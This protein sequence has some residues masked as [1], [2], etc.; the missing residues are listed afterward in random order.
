M[1]YLM[2][3]LTSGF[4]VSTASAQSKEEL[5][6]KEACDYTK[7]RLVSKL[8]LWVDNDMK[9]ERRY[10]Y[11]KEL[12]ESFEVI[13][14]DGDIDLK[15]A[16]PEKYLKKRKAIREGLIDNLN[17]LANIYNAVCKD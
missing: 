4:L 17:A 10:E 14:V 9:L 2:I 7:E 15:I 3:L 13:D 16:N 1:K 8:G 5:S 11:E 6:F 12:E